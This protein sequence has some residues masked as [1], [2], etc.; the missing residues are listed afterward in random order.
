MTD[1]LGRLT[2]TLAGRYTVERELGQGGM[3]TVY[4]AHLGQ[5]SF[6]ALEQVQ[7]KARGLPADLSA[8]R[9]R[10]S[11]GNRRSTDRSSRMK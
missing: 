11:G 5:G 9:P 7:A 2:A 4:L 3:A 8:L 1:I 6:T 10:S